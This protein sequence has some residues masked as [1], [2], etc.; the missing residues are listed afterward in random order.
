MI[1]DTEIVKKFAENLRDLMKERDVSA[2][3]LSKA[4]SIPK[5]SISEWLTGRQP[6]LDENIVRLA[7]FF[8]VSVEKLITGWEPE[9][10]IIK[11]FIDQADDGFVE[12]HGGIYRFR[13]EKFIGPVK[14]KTQKGEK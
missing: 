7:R 5:S 1:S 4:V 10:A 13:I 11:S 6:K 3:T 14:K 8:G 9:E 12:I 2:A